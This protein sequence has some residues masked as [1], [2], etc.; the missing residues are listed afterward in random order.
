MGMKD[1]SYCKDCGTSITYGT[2]LCESCESNPVKVKSDY[3]ITATSNAFAWI[4]IE[5]DSLEQAL[6]IARK[7]P[8]GLWD[9]EIDYTSFAETID[10][11]EAK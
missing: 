2:E 10:A 8:I 3:Q 4:T 5:A 9:M 6:E 11:G 7:T 1:E